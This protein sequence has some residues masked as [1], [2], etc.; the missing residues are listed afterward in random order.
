M[1]RKPDLK[2]N[3][4]RETNPEPVFQEP[5][6]P[7]VAPLIVIGM[8]VSLVAPAGITPRNQ[9]LVCTLGIILIWLIYKIV[10]IERQFRVTVNEVAPEPTEALHSVNETNGN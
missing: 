6:T 5:K 1:D 8:M 2:S 3:Y 10:W 9:I 4:P 7:L